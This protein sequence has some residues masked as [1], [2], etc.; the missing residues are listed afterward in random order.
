MIASSVS[1]CFTFKFSSVR[2]M[3]RYSP[4]DL[5]VRQV[6]ATLHCPA[7]RY[8]S[9]G[10]Q[11]QKPARASPAGTC[12]AVPSG[13]PPDEG[14]DGRGSILPAPTWR[15][16][17]CHTGPITSASGTSCC[18]AMTHAC[19]RFQDTSRVPAG[20]AH[21]LGSP[22]WQ[23]RRGR[24][25][26]AIRWACLLRFVLSASHRLAE[27]RRSTSSTLPRHLLDRQDNPPA[28]SWRQP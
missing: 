13:Y 23:G 21:F 22:S 10:W 20:P 7:R 19:V 11:G 1:R 25:P 15:R 26:A 18:V 2:V 12:C 16:P 3:L 24:H 8:R 6:V 9:G 27:G 28:G 17:V 14:A 4:H 5:L